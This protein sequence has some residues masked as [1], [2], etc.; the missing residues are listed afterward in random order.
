MTTTVGVY[1]DFVSPYAWLG[2]AATEAFAAEHALRFEPRPVVYAALLDAAG[3]VGPAESPSKRIYTFVDA[4][5][6]A[7][8]AGLELRGPP[9]HPFRSLD[10]LR[11]VCVFRD[12]PRALALAVT[13]AH[14]AWRDG[15]DLT[16]PAVRAEIVAA[17]GLDA[18]D[19]EERIGAPEAKS[20]LRELTEDAIARGIFGVPTYALSTPE[21][22]EL[23]WGQDRLAHLAARLD[24]RLPPPPSRGQLAIL[25]RPRGVDRKGAPPTR[26]A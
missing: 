26:P 17:V 10:A 18:D 3:L 2:L 23:F 25:E 5:R 1:F 15:R 12:D 8:L 6:V 20:T 14:A 22:T 19:L 13:F 16:D 24:G 11:A 7:R 21:G 9:A 4:A